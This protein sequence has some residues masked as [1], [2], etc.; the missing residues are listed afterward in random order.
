MCSLRSQIGYPENIE[1]ILLVHL[2]IYLL[3]IYICMYNTEHGMDE[4]EQIPKPKILTI[5]SHN[6]RTN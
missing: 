5:C 1:R 6:V 4:Y 2:F 3:V